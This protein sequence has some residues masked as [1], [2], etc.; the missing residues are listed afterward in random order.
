[1]ASGATYAV[2]VTAQPTGPS[3]TCTVTGGTGTV[4]AA[5]V[6][7]VAVACSTSTFTVGGT[8]TGLAG[9]GLVL[10]NGTENLPISANGA[11]T[12]LTPVASGGSYAVTVT[13]QPTGPS[14]TCTVTGGTG[15]VGAANV[16]TVAVACSTSTFT[17]GGTVTGLAGTGLV[18][19]NGTENLPISAN[20]AFTFL[21]PVAS[22]GSYAVTVT[23]QPTGPSQ[24][25]TVTGGT[26][27]VG[28]ANV[29]TVA[30]ACST[31]TFTVGGTVTGLAGTGLVLHNG[32][33]NLPIS[34]NG[35]FTFL[36][37]VASG[38]SY[39]VTVTAQP[40]GPSQTC[41]VTGGTGTVT[42]ANVTTVA[43]AC[44][45][46]T[47]TVGGTVTGLAGT[48]LVLHNGT[49]NLPIS[50]NGAFTFLTP[51]ASGGS[52]AVTATAQPTGP[53]QTC[54]VTGGTGTVTNANVTTVAV[55]CT[56]NTYTVGGTVTGLTGAG[57]VLRNGNENLPITA[58]GGAPVPFTFTTPVA[59]GASYNVRVQSDPIGQTCTF[60][61][62]TDT[63]TV[64][65]ANVTTV[66]VTCAP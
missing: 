17:V 4:G 52:Y 38:G 3:Q 16:T 37:R 28:A 57:L 44:S 9:T 47:F 59:S 35:A 7:T 64:G 23:A 65:G 41:T 42:N 25:C 66:A 21:T 30:V 62:G 32:T 5:N 26:G 61:P 13:A 10:H 63:G 2:T 20:G 50:A 51:V 48:G 24:T 12:F 40:T 54:T 27:T 34:A 46:S 1:M 31:S 55:A 22:G 56:T 11:F 43:V 6:T 53:S 45:T 39:A 60:T 19:H 58:L 29:T 8:V 14:Q 33:E 15:T 18:L 36:T 49:E